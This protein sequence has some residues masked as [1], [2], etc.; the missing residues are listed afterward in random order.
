MLHLVEHT[1]WKI[2]ETKQKVKKNVWKKKDDSWISRWATLSRS[3]CVVFLTLTPLTMNYKR[4][5]QS[6]L[7]CARNLKALF[8]RLHLTFTLSR[9]SILHCS[10]RSPPLNTC[11]F[12]IYFVCFF[13]FIFF[14]SL[15]L[16]SFFYSPEWIF[17][18]FNRN[19]I[20]SFF[21]S[22]GR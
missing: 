17:A 1:R 4:Q 2:I 16:T 9:F 11:S 7:S 14:L 15:F 22:R 19:F 12:F 20:V 6:F 13:P 3:A 21:F 18:D 10:Y 5:I 8:F